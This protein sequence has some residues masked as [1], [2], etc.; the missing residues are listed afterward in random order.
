[1]SSAEK[2]EALTRRNAP[3]L[4]SAKLP[5]SVIILTSAILCASAIFAIA[6]AFTVAISLFTAGVVGFGCWLAFWSRR[7]R[8]RYGRDSTARRDGNALE[9]VWPPWVRSVVKA[10]GIFLVVLFGATFVLILIYVGSR[11][12]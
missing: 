7:L 8:V 5:L 9:I 3:Q 11:L 4:I 6:S 12:A 10:Y 2:S 1:L